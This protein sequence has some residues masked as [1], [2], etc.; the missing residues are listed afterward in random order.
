MSRPKC[1]GGLGFKKLHEFNLAIVGK[2]AWRLGINPSSL[3]AE[4]LKAKYFPNSNYLDAQVGSNPSFLWRSIWECKILIKQ[5]AYCRVG[6]G[7]SIMIWKDVWL[8]FAP[9]MKITTPR[10]TN[11]SVFFVSNLIVNGIWNHE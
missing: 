4:L 8:P 3:V 5:G 9:L 1:F 11:T 7:S 10:P 2:Q 6:N